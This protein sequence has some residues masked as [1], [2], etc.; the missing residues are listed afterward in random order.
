MAFL[1]QRIM[2]PTYLSVSSP[3]AT[4]G[5]QS[6]MCSWPMLRKG[7]DLQLMCKNEDV[8]YYVASD[9]MLKCNVGSTRR[10]HMYI[11]RASGLLRATHIFAK[12]LQA[13]LHFAN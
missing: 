12:F 2:Q 11:Y 1:L 8:I 10:Y 6:H 4:N 13:A 9:V 7:R 3:L 5:V